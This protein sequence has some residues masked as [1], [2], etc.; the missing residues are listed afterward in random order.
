[1]ISIAQASRRIVSTKSIRT[2]QCKGFLQDG[3]REFITV[4]A[5]ANA[6]GEKM[7]PA[8][9]YASESGHMQDTWIEDVDLTQQRAFFSVSSTGWTSNE[10]G[11]A[12]LERFQQ[13]TLERAKFGEEWRLLLLD[14]H[15]SHINLAFCQKALASNILVCVYPPHTTHRLQP[16]DVSVFRPLA[17]YYS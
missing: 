1:L 11:M 12:W 9:I 14:G 5:G 8:L 10:H 16:L 15:S 7:A 17:H 2:G 4:I 13:E 3:N 6:I